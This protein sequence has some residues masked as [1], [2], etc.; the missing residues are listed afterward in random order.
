MEAAPQ[1]T[2]QLYI[3]LSHGIKENLTLGKIKA[4]HTTILSSIYMLEYL[5]ASRF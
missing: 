3:I 4:C 2:L 1:L 5:K